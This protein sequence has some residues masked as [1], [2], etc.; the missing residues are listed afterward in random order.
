[1]GTPATATAHASRTVYGTCP[2]EALSVADTLHHTARRLDA[3]EQVSGPAAPRYIQGARYS[4][5]TS[6][7]PSDRAQMAALRRNPALRS[8]TTRT[9]LACVYDQADALCHPHRSRS[10][11]DQKPHRMSLAARR[12]PNAARTDTHASMLQRGFGELVKKPTTP[13][14]TR[15]DTERNSFFALNAA[16][17]PS[18]PPSNRSPGDPRD[19]DQR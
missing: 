1:M 17:R 5:E 15:A 18:N 13:P 19:S 9:R 3:G 7:A 4:S 11:S 14:D 8:M 16:T 12:M 6:M 2:I 10:N